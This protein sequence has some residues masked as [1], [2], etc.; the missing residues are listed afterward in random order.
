MQLNSFH[1]EFDD[2]RTKRRKTHFTS[3]VLPCVLYFISGGSLLS[4]LARKRKKWKSRQSSVRLYEL[5]HKCHGERVRERK[6]KIQQIFRL[7][8]TINGA[9][10]ALMMSLKINFYLEDEK[11]GLFCVLPI[12]GISSMPD[13]LDEKRK[14][15]HPED[16]KPHNK[17]RTSV[18]LPIKTGN[19]KF[20]CTYLNRMCIE[21]EIFCVHREKHPSHVCGEKAERAEMMMMSWK[22]TFLL[23]FI[24]LIIFQ[25]FLRE[26]LLFCL[27]SVVTFRLFLTGFLNTI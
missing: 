9:S 10:L 19:N 25:S 8:E 6:L 5:T 26:L 13:D 1:E 17:L 22:R 3:L 12:S 24:C 15:K 18:N 4:H 20:L 14:K 2:E 21:A 7:N 16:N 27:V 23:L 11:K